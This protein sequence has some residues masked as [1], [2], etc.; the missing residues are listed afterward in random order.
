MKTPEELAEE[1]ACK[2]GIVSWELNNIQDL[3]K[4]F[5]AGYAAAVEQIT[6]QEQEK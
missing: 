1:Y 6:T 3:E 2:E 5:L 4:A